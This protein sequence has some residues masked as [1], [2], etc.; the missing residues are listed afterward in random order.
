MSYI[1]LCFRK[2]LSG[3]QETGYL[4]F[5]MPVRKWVRLFSGF[6]GFPLCNQGLTP[7]TATQLRVKTVM[8]DKHGQ[9]E[10]PASM[11]C[12][13]S[14]LS[15]MLHPSRIISQIRSNKVLFYPS[16]GIFLF[17]LEISG[18]IPTRVRLEILE[19]IRIGGQILFAVCRDGEASG[20]YF[21]CS[22]P[23]TAGRAAAGWQEFRAEARA[24]MMLGKRARA[25]ARGL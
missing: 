22:L 5:I 13:Y 17:N 21:F 24:L 4:Q 7:I 16:K 3:S 19:S 12:V 14:P 20:A 9:E 15:W 11:M 8:K 2:V 23:C 6:T 10:L 1:Q 18:I 25:R